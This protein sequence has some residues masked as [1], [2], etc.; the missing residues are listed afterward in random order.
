MRGIAPA[1]TTDRTG[2][3]N[4]GEQN[5]HENQDKT[6]V[7]LWPGRPCWQVPALPMLKE[8]TVG[9]FLEWPMPF[10][11][12]KVHGTYDEALGMTVNWRQPSTPARR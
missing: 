1:V 10:Q 9:Y 12:A 4:Q 5:S 2:K 7:V 11:Y 8:L 3:E 6:D